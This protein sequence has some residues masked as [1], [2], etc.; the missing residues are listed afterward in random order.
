MRKPAPG[1]ADPE[2]DRVADDNED[3]AGHPSAPT[4]R[5]GAR[6]FCSQAESLGVAQMRLKQRD[7]AV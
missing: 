6:A 3:T 1:R 2:R 7:R 5:R 4:N